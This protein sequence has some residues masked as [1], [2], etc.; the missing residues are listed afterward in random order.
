MK[1]E[2]LEVKGLRK[3]VSAY[4]SELRYNI[5]I[6][7]EDGRMEA[8]KVCADGDDHPVCYPWAPVLNIPDYDYLMATGKN[9]TATDCVKFG[10]I[11]AIRT[12]RKVMSDWEKGLRH[13]NPINC[14]FT[15]GDSETLDDFWYVSLYTNH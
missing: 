14:D 10:V 6:N 9:W 2:N 12:A 7:I 11:D 13:V 5:Y 4:K 1:I 8:A 15:Y 3:C